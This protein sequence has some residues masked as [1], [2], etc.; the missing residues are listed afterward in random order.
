MIRFGTV[1]DSPGIP[2]RIPKGSRLRTGHVVSSTG[3]GPAES[4]GLRTEWAPGPPDPNPEAAVGTSNLISGAADRRAG[5]GAR[6]HFGIRERLRALRV[7]GFVIACRNGHLPHAS[8]STWTSAPAS[9]WDSLR[10]GVEEASHGGRAESSHPSFSS[11]GS[12][13]K[14]GR[15]FPAT[16]RGR[17]RALATRMASRPSD[18]RQGVLT[19]ERW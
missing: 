18:A 10:G 3:P 13:A 12:G 9:S 8:S 19:P 6:L 1:Q 11:L 16:G 7:R 2:N 4:L 15:R 17:Q 14:G 5:C